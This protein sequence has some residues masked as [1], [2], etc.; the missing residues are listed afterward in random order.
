MLRRSFDNGQTWGEVQVVADD[1]THTLGN[2]CPVVDHETGT[3][4][5][6][7][8]KN[9]RQIFVTKVPT[10]VRPGRNRLKLPTPSRTRSG[11]M[12]GRV[13]GTASS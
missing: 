9:N 2:E 3:I 12:L 13:L 10:T 7:F 11:V 4:L 6:P 1:G 8:C 5:L